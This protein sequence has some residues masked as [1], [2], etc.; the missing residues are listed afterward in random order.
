MALTILRSP[1]FLTII[2]ILLIVMS[3]ST[4]TLLLVEAGVL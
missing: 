4:I 1:T 3:I 2:I